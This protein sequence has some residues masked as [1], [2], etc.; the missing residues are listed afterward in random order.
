MIEFHGRLAAG[1]AIAMIRRLEPFD[2]AWCEE[3]VAP[4]SLELL[5]EVKRSVRARSP[6]ASGSTRW[7]IFID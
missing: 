1:T 2:P 4:E 7:Q 3:P 5:A 6:R